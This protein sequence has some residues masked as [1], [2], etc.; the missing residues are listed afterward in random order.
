MYTV[1]ECLNI[2]K[3]SRCCL[4]PSFVPIPVNQLF[5]LWRRNSPTAHY[6]SNPLCDSCSLI[7]RYP[8]ALGGNCWPCSCCLCQSGAEAL[9]V[10]YATSTP[11]P[12]P[13]ASAPYRYY[14][15][16]P[17]AQPTTSQLLISMTEAR[18][19]QPSSVG[20]KVTSITHFSLTELA[21]K[22][23]FS[24]LLATALDRSLSVVTH[25]QRH[26]GRAVKEFSRIMH[27]TRFTEVIW[28]S[29]FS[30]A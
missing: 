21:V 20:M 4:P 11:Y 29:A 19:S 13:A 7:C 22:T 28:P 12:V 25:R 8:T 15:L 23:L 5:F 30:S 9:V 24:L 10:G 3:Y 27:A 26:P 6:P 16:S 1:V 18:Y 14:L 17:I 2:L